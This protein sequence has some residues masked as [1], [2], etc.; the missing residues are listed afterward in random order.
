MEADV[1]GSDPDSGDLGLGRERCA[2]LQALSSPSRPHPSGNA[3]LFPLWSHFIQQMIGE[4][5]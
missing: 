3:P 1:G 4:W 5:G 2:G